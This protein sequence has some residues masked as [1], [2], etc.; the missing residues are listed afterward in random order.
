MFSSDREKTQRALMKELVSACLGD[1]EKAIRLIEYERGLNPMIKTLEATESALDRLCYDRG[2]CM[3]EATYDPKLFR[4]S[5]QAAGLEP[6]SP[7]ARQGPPNVSL[8]MGLVVVLVC[9]LSF[10]YFT[11]TSKPKLPGVQPGLPAM[12]NNVL[13]YSP[14]PQR[15]PREAR[16]AEDSTLPRITPERLPAPAKVTTYRSE[17]GASQNI[18]KCVSNGRTVYSD[19]A[20]GPSAERLDVAVADTSG[21]VPA[22]VKSLDDHVARRI[23]TESVYEKSIQTQRVATAEQRKKMECE[24]LAKHI[25]WL[26]SMSRQPQS[27]QAQDWI[28]DEKARAQ[29]RELEL[30]C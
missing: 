9:L 27:R 23:T 8:R 1:K 12:S 30:R 19:Q 16:Q 28:R 4:R 10:G 14:P 15:P 17:P 18:F 25:A 6:L 3:R 29:S 2:K 21:F 22:S 13:G 26:D 7:G 24:A 20:C 5:S 11:R